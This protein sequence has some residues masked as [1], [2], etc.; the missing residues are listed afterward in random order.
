M[1]THKDWT[2]LKPV[3]IGAPSIPD[4]MVCTPTFKCQSL[5]TLDATD[6]C[7][8]YSQWEH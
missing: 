6:R 8:P 5:A 2:C 4:V 1:H 3:W 7:T